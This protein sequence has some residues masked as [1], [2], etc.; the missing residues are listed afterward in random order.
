MKFKDL[1]EE[2]TVELR[3]KLSTIWISFFY[4]IFGEH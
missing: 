1:T 3:P 4:K 2:I